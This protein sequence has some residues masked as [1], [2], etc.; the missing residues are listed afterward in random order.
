MAQIFYR[1]VIRLGSQLNSNNEAQPSYNHWTSVINRN[2]IY[3]LALNL[4]QNI[5]SI[6]EKSL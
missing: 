1:C 6:W 3:Q 4:M 2:L 5:N